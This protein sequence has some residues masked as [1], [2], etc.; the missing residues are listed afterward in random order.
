MQRIINSSV[1]ASIGV[2]PATI[3]YGSAINLE[4]GLLEIDDHSQLTNNTSMEDFVDKLQTLQQ[5]IIASARQ[6]Q[7]E[8]DTNHLSSETIPTRKRKRN[9][10]SNNSLIEEF[11]SGDYVLVNYPNNA[12]GNKPP[13]KL[14]THLKGPYRV[15]SHDG[16]RY[17]IQNLSTMMNES[18]HISRLRPFNY[19]PSRVNPSAI[20]TKEMNMFVI[21]EIISHKGNLTGPKSG[22]TFRVRWQNCPVEDDTWEPWNSLFKTVALHKYLNKIGKSNLIPKAFKMSTDTKG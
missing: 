1:N 8:T 6:Q 22:L 9:Q 13:N 10:S 12:F 18:V 16:P 21:D 4:R 17:E 15:L 5:R 2:A 20:A 19:D 7:L 14:L 11:K 3:I